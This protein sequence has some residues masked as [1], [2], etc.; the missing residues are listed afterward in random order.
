MKW[1]V[2]VC[3]A[4]VA[5]M[6]LFAY[7]APPVAVLNFTPAAINFMAREGRGLAEVLQGNPW[8]RPGCKRVLYS[9]AS[10]SDYA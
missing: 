1:N 3:S 4:L 6:F 10:E 7:G 2:F 5:W 8:L 9:V